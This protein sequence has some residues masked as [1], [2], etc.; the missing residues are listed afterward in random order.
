MA[1]AHLPARLKLGFAV[2]A[3]WVVEGSDLF[4]WL[5][6]YAGE[7]FEAANDAYYAS[8]ARQAIDPDPT[9]LL[10]ATEDWPLRPVV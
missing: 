4:V 2:P 3:A 6:E 10:A 1:P 5:L 8:P 9:R 7:D